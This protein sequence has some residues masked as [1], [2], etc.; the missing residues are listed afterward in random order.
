MVGDGH[1]KIWRVDDVASTF[2][3]MSFRRAIQNTIS[4]PSR[5]LLF[6]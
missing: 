5:D 4:T 1:D 3:G 2:L 6:N